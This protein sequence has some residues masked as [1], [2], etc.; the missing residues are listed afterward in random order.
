MYKEKNHFGKVLLKQ[1]KTV[2]HI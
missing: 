1:L 2:W